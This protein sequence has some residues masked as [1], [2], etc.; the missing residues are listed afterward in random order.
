MTVP[1]VKDLSIDDL[2]NLIR[3]TVEEALDHRL[4]DLAA[5]SSGAFLRSVEEARTDY[6]EGR[7]TPLD[8]LLDG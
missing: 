6:R 1:A 7:V 3:D 5:L 8:D 4:E 2:R